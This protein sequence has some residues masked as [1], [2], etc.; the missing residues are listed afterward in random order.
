MATYGVKLLC[1]FSIMIA[2]SCGTAKK[3]EKA[4][5]QNE[6]WAANNA[7]NNIG[8]PGD[9]DFARQ[10]Y[11]RLEAN[12]I[13]FSN[14][15]AKIKIE[16][17]TAGNKK[18]E[19]NAFLR[20]K[21]DSAIW[22]TVNAMLGIEAFRLMITPDTVKIM[23]KLNKAYRVEPFGFLHTYT[24]YPFDF[25]A[26]QDLLIGNPVI[27]QADQNDSGNDIT[28]KNALFATKDLQGRVL[29]SILNAYTRNEFILSSDYYL[30]V[31]NHLKDRD[32]AVE[33][34]CLLNYFNY[35]RKGGSYFSTMREVKLSGSNA[36]ELYLDYK[37]FS[38]NEPLTFPF[39]IPKNYQLYKM[40]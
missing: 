37:Q 10:V 4:S 16:A 29:L 38:F 18:N 22:V 17:N 27:I 1:F 3:L 12:R 6:K 2:C 39:T 7:Q 30:T 28:G 25:Q 40:Q 9:A 14:F 34:S 15:S 21:K 13:D 20:I 8:D 11:S 24:N 19:F 33:Q 31:T 23:D 5:Q 35:V 32:T 26:I 36:L